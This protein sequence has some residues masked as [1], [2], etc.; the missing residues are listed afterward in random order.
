VC[1][2]LFAELFRTRTIATLVGFLGLRGERLFLTV[3]A[4]G[5]VAE[6]VVLGFGI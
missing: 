1:L 3:L 2:G 4:A 6:A 5:E